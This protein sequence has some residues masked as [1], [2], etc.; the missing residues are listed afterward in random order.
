MENRDQT[1][2]GRACRLSHSGN[3]SPV[4]LQVAG[5]CWLFKQAPSLMDGGG[6]VLFLP[7]FI[8]FHMNEMWVTIRGVVD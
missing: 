7:S 6:R 5:H 2:V 3:L 1:I 8:G 4:H